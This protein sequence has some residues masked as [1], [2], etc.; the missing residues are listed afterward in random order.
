[1]SE[2]TLSDLAAR[3]D[4]IDAK[5]AAIAVTASTPIPRISYTRAEF[6]AMT[7]RSAKSLRH[8]KYWRALGGRKVGGRVMFPESARL[9]IAEGKK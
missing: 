4:A 9:A 8:P 2:P 6:A 7:G 1:M 3:L 5:L